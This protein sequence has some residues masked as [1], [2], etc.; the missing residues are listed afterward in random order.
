MKPVISE[1]KQR[2]SQALRE[3]LKKRKQQALQRKDQPPFEI[4]P[5]RDEKD[6]SPNQDS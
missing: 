1:K 3:N 5:S 2:M 6:S 4:E